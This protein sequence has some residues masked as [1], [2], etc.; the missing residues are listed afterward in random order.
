MRRTGT[1]CFFPQ[2]LRR[3]LPNRRRKLVIQPIVSDCHAHGDLR[4]IEKVTWIPIFKGADRGQLSLG[5]HEV[6]AFIRQAIGERE[7]G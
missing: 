2:S 6:A 1:E 7:R 5:A 3:Q 4:R